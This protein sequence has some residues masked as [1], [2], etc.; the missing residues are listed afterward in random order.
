M[1][2]KE[3]GHCGEVKDV[4]QF[5][6]CKARKDGLQHKCKVCNK[7]QND[8]YRN[9]KPEYWS[10]ETGY[11]SDRKKW[12]YMLEYQKADKSIKVYKINLPD[13]EIYIGSTKRYMNTR[14]SSH[15]NDYKMWKKGLK[16]KYIPGLYDAFDK[17]DS[18]DDLKEHL[19]ENTFVLEETMGERTRQHKREQWWMDRY[20]EQGKNL[21]NRQRAYSAEHRYRRKKYGY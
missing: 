14:M 11:F 3:C 15:I 1:A 18:I 13:G 19:S 21:I 10:Y 5:S 12:K 6:K 17:F 7:I 20:V 4:S 2:K 9:E 8:A 16:K